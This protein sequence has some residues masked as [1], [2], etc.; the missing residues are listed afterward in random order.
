[1]LVGRD[2]ELAEAVRLLDDQG[3]VVVSGPAGIGKTTLA[4]A[5]LVAAGGRRATSGMASLTWSALLPFR[6]LH[7]SLE[8]EHAEAAAAAVLRDGDDA[9]LLDDLQ[10]FDEA[11]L[12]VVGML[13]GRLPLLATVRAGEPGADEVLALA[14]LVG[15]RRLPLDPLAEADSAA[16]LAAVHPNLDGARRRSVLA[17][18]GGNPLLLRELPLGADA[19]P[20]LVSALAPRVDSLSP[21][22]RR[23]AATLAVLG[24]PV[25][26]A[27]LGRGGSELVA[28]GLAADQGTT[29]AFAH[30]LLGEVIGE[31]LRTE[32]NALRHEVA[33]MVQPEE[34]AHLLLEAGDHARAREVALAA[35]EGLDPRARRRRAQ[36]LEVAALASHPIDAELRFEAARAL[37]ETGRPQR[38]LALALVEGRDAMDRHPRGLLVGAEALAR[39]ALGHHRA[40]LELVAQAVA[41]LQG[42]R[43]EAEVLALAGSTIGA[44]YVD[45]DGRPVVDRAWEAVHLSEELGLARGYAR[46][47]LASVLMTAGDPTWQEHARAAIELARQEGD[48]DLR[49]T[50]MITSILGAWATGD[51]RRAE[52]LALAE[53]ARGP[54]QDHD[55][56]WSSVIAYAALLGV[57]GGGPCGPVIEQFLP[58]LHDEPFFRN[59]A[60]LEAAMVLALSDVGRHTEAA[61]LAKGA[62]PRAGSDPNMRSIVVWARIECAWAAGRCAE[63]IAGLDELEGLAVGSYPSAALAR[64]VAGH[65]AR[66]LG[67][68]PTGPAPGVLLPAWAAAATE[69]EALLAASSAD[70]G[71]RAS[72]PQRFVAAAEAWS[73]ADRR[74]ELRCRWAAADLAVEGGRDDV[75]ELVDVAVAL[76]RTRGDRAMLGRLGRTARRAGLRLQVPSRPRV[77]PLSGREVEV[78]ELVGAGLTSPRIAAVLGLS[79]ATVDGYIRGAKQKLGTPTRVAAAS[80]L[81]AMR[82]PV[83]TAS[84]GSPSS[85]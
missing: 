7:R 47:R 9:L 15:G 73:G 50:A 71:E 83:A 32:A 65:A 38:A 11:S 35:M 49:R 53:V 23:A 27:Q 33:A 42:S 77:G 68:A 62:V 18:A 14:A 67:S 12:D 85:G 63:A 8:L 26:P 29:T 76:A 28:A 10:W 75:A 43:S 61:A 19:A 13:V 58:F 52:E 41:D 37:I 17:T 31:H 55:R 6:R 70:R 57:L 36:L 45:L 79:P 39:W 80:R 69:W 16:L 21:A 54:D 25:P 59:R 40:C 34:A 74:S 5:A 84:A 3:F 20:T 60:F 30:P 1:M 66:E 81:A 4:R 64:V 51:V 24:R 2:R 78:L 56:A 46:S 72:A 22:G 48:D 44:T 82:A